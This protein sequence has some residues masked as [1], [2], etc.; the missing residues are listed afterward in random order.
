LIYRAVNDPSFLI[1]IILNVFTGFMY[2][3]LLLIVMRPFKKSTE[4]QTIRL[5]L[6][7]RSDYQKM[8]LKLLY[9]FAHLVWTNTLR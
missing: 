1:V 5:F 4:T 2:L 8:S 3:L 9:N 6:K 7:G